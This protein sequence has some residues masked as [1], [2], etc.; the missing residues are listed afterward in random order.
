MDAHPP[1]LPR[2]Y[3]GPGPLGLP[4]PGWLP[5]PAFVSGASDR[6]FGGAD[7]FAGTVA[8]GPPRTGSYGL[9]RSRRSEER[10]PLRKGG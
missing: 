3:R 5:C 4:P 6:A 10:T 7:G 9:K 1:A 2:C 8:S